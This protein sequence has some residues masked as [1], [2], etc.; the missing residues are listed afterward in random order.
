MAAAPSYPIT[1][2]TDG[3]QAKG[4]EK[5]SDFVQ[6]PFDIA[7]IKAALIKIPENEKICVTVYFPDFPDFHQVTIDTH[8]ININLDRFTF[9]ICKMKHSSKY[10]HQDIEMLVNE[11]L[12]VADGAGY[13]PKEIPK[14]RSLKLMASDKAI[15]INREKYKDFPQEVIDD[16]FYDYFTSLDDMADEPPKLREHE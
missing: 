3:D 5:I 10:G 8:F 11:L 16:L 7:R 2:I 12:Y 14:V 1:S 4:N 9:L 13:Q 15:A 6:D